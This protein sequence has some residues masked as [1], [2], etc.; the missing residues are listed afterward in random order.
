MAGSLRQFG[1]VPSP[2]ALMAASPAALDGFGRLLH[3]F[4]RSSLAPLEREVLI[5]T[6]AR[7]N[8]CHYC[9]AMHSALT[10]KQ[11]HAHLLPALRDGAPLAD[12]KLEALRQF[13]LALLERRGAATDEDLARFAAA[14]FTPE[15][16]LDAVV[17]IGLFT[18]ST[19]ANRL[20]RAPLD[21]AFE[22]FAWEDRAPAGR[23]TDC[24]PRGW[25][26]ERRHHGA[27][28]LEK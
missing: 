10:A 19:F 14:G 22:P 24:A 27:H 9:M 1:F 18:L 26:S 6:V 5:F 3:V 2:V 13:V 21:A 23:A 15:N 17:G 28:W 25:S 4:E 7:R 12:A 11:G 20:T 16:A 8:G